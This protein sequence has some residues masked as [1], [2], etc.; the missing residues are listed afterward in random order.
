MDKRFEGKV[1]VITGG[2][3]GIGKGI[4][5]RFVR[6]GAKV[7]VVA[8]DPLVHETAAE[9]RAMGAQAI[10]AEVDVTSSEQVAALYERVAQELTRS[11]SRSR[12]PVSSPSRAWKI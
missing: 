1:V 4:A 3:R 12:T 5:E 9:L 10:S 6:E 7:C 8:N 2:S 11:I